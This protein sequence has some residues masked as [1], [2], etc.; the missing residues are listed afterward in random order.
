MAC[1]DLVTD[2]IFQFSSIMAQKL[3]KNI[4]NRTL[5][6]HS[7]NRVNDKISNHIKEGNKVKEM[8]IVAEVHYP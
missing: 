7:C 4:S 2:A 6:G 1:G 3:D 8:Q 5:E